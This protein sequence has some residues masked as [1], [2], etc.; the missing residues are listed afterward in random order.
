M[1]LIWLLPVLTLTHVVELLIWWVLHSH[2][3]VSILGHLVTLHQLFLLELASISS[4]LIDG[5]TLRMAH[6]LWLWLPLLQVAQLI[7]IHP[8]ILA[9]ILIRFMHSLVLSE[10][11]LVAV[12]MLVHDRVLGVWMLMLVLLHLLLSSHV[13]TPTAIALI[14]LLLVVLLLQV[15]IKVAQVSRLLRLLLLLLLL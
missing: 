3:T 10:L 13:L 15:D 1:V 5:L 4:L 11:S 2:L 9:S 12:W 14:L 7:I 6:L 8:L